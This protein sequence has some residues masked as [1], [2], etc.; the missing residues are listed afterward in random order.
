M[1]IL[2]LELP[3]IFS[4]LSNLRQ[5]IKFCLI[6]ITFYIT[7]LYAYISLYT[8]FSRKRKISNPSI[9]SPLHPCYYY[10]YYNHFSRHIFCVR[11]RQYNT[12]HP[13]VLFTKGSGARVRCLP[14]FFVHY[15][16]PSLSTLHIAYP[17]ILCCSIQTEF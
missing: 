12:R 16:P 3:A 1:A 6:I 15:Y 11:S 8:L 10:Y 13:F 5:R 9:H 17:I 4:R 7:C 2:V 14:L